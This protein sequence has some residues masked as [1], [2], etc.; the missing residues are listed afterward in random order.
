MKYSRFIALMRNTG[1]KIVLKD[2][3][4]ITLDA[5]ECSLRAFGCID[6]K[7]Q[8]CEITLLFPSKKEKPLWKKS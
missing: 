6:D 7:M 5:W 2:N 4:V 1:I 3:S 8:S